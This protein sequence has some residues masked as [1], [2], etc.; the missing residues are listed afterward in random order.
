VK[1]E[2]IGIAPLKIK[3]CKSNAFYTPRQMRE[4]ENKE[5]NMNNQYFIGVDMGYGYFKYFSREGWGAIRSAAANGYQASTEILLDDD[6]QEDTQYSNVEAIFLDGEAVAV[7]EQALGWL[8][9]LDNTRNDFHRSPAALALLQ[10]SLLQATKE[11]GTKPVN[12]NLTLALPGAN[13]GA[14]KESLANWL[15]AQGDTWR[16]Q[17]IDS[18]GRARKKTIT[19]QSVQII[20]QPQAHLLGLW[21]TNKGGVRNTRRGLAKT[22]II[23][24]GAGTCDIGLFKSF[25]SHGELTSP[26]GGWQIVRNVGKAL[27][28][29]IPDYNPDRF[30][31]DE[32]IQGNGKA[33]YRGETYD[34][35]TVIEKALEKAALGVI[36]HLTSTIPNA[37]NT[38]NILVVGGW[39]E[40]LFSHILTHIPHATLVTSLFGKN[41]DWKNELP[42]DMPIIS[43]AARG[44]YC[45]MMLQESRKK[46]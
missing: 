24:L 15:K 13:F 26:S 12:A 30:D 23:D 46:R 5:N 2:W 7:G 33:F 8:N 22:I 37:M 10:A 4:K 16:I 9:R 38:P 18:A 42:A 32:I 45:Y 29:Q 39:G 27:Q 6:K 19:M 40:R 25:R 41:G 34:M 36:N 3:H 11:T 31:L 44:C 14:Q 17:F 21:M 20:L 1:R 35:T 28:T 43:L